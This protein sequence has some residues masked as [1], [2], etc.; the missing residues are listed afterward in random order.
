MLTDL[1]SAVEATHSSTHSPPDGL[2]SLIEEP[3]QEETI[4]TPPLV[5]GGTSPQYKRKRTS[6][7]RLSTV[8][9]LEY[10]LSNP[11]YMKVKN[12]LLTYI[13]RWFLPS[14]SYQ[15]NR[16]EL[17]KEM[18]FATRDNISLLLEVCRQ[19]FLTLT[20]PAYMK[21]LIELYRYWIQ[22]QV[23]RR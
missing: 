2:H 1:S 17:M 18:W 12:I 7:Y 16:V 22:V 3:S 21:S 20:E 15:G 10:D 4:Q 19:G 13:L 6:P 11:V 23:M 8:I 14:T 9:K 5:V